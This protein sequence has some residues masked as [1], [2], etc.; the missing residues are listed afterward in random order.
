M[1]LHIQYKERQ[2]CCNAKV[3]KDQVHEMFSESEANSEDIDI[4]THS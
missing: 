4:N 3:Q 2:F 1:S